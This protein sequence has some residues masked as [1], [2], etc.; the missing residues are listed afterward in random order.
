MCRFAGLLVVLLT[1]LPVHADVYL[2]TDGGKMWKTCQLGEAGKQENVTAV[3]VKGGTVLAAAGH[4][5]VGILALSVDG[6]KKWARIH[7]SRFISI[8]L[9]GDAYASSV[10]WSGSL[11]LAVFQY[12]T[13]V[14]TSPEPVFRPAMNRTLHVR[15][16]VGEWTPLD[17]PAGKSPVALRNSCDGSSVWLLAK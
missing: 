3:G 13:Y 7:K 12:G 9:A 4:V 14:D 11:M 8:A 6:G 1:A 10:A 17:A 2:T 15:E 5:D 16:G